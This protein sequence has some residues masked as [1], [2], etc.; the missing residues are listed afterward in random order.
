MRKGSSLFLPL[1]WFAKSVICRQQKCI[2]SRQVSA[3]GLALGKAHKVLPERAFGS[4]LQSLPVV[5]KCYK[6]NS[7][8]CTYPLV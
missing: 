4:E 3:I 5:F 2:K 7:C 8:L 1:G 6:I